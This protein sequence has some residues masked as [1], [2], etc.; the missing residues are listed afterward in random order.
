MGGTVCFTSF[1]FAYL[2]RA[3]VL[4]GTLAEAHPN[5]PLHAL[6]VDR[7]PADLDPAAIAPFASVTYADELGI[8]D[9]RVWL[10]DHDLV[11]ACTA[12]KGTMLC[13]LLAEGAER[14]I[15]FDP[16]IAL[17]HPLDFSAAEAASVV[18]TPHQA[19]PN[20]VWLARQD[21]E[22]GSLRYGIYNLGFL[23]VRND[24]A[25]RAFAAWWAE[26]TLEDCRDA[27]EEGFFT[28]QKYCDLVPGL[29]DNVFVQRHP[30]WNVASWNLSLREITAGADGA[31]LANGHRLSFYHFTKIGGVGDVM[32]E[33]YAGDNLAVYELLAWYRRE[34]AA[35]VLLELDARPWAFGSFADGMPITPAARELWRHRQDLRAAFPDP[36]A[37]GDATLQ[38]WLRHE[39]PD[40]LSSPGTPA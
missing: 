20:T 15:Y 25:G 30:G 8:P 35:N 10:F 36:F 31:L 39:R 21:G 24:A 9:F 37:A 7:P 27:P 5:W 32:T 38:A 19:A 34:V 12:V 13:R 14:V 29:F 33:R 6:L 11:E 28:D 2:A 17:F 23:A 26:R 16:D 22:F 4:A 1:T 3:R 40:L 18:L